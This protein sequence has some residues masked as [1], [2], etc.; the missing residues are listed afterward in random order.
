M[1]KELTERKHKLTTRLAECKENKEAL[2]GQQYV[3][4]ISSGASVLNKKIDGVQE[5]L[6]AQQK[7][8]F[9]KRQ[10]DECDSILL[11]CVTNC[12]NDT[13]CISNCNRDYSECILNCSG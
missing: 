9:D 13:N 12:D 5:K 6:E 3:I 8:P 7:V 4:D 1:R 10:C 2:N 11:D